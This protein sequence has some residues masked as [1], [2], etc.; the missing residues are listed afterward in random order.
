MVES[1]SENFVSVYKY[2]SEIS[3]QKLNAGICI[4]SLYINKYK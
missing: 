2:L 1:K 3:V 4:Q